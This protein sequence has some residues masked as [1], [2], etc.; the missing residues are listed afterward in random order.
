M[1]GRF[2]P[3]SVFMGRKNIRAGG[4]ERVNETVQSRESR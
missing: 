1:G 4:E 2:K 3:K